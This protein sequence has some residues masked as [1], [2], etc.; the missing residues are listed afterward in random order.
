MPARKKVHW[1]H[2]I[3]QVFLQSNQACK[4]KGGLEYYTNKEVIH[5]VLTGI[6]FEQLA[7]QEELS[8]AVLYHVPQDGWT[9]QGREMELDPPKIISLKTRSHQ[10]IQWILKTRHVS[11]SLH[12]PIQIHLWN[13]NSHEN[14]SKWHH[15]CKTSNLSHHNYGIVITLDFI[16]MEYGGRWYAP[17]ISPRITGYGRHVVCIRYVYSI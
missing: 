17:R 14:H 1:L 16:L 12:H 8:K 5:R 2:F 3:P 4:S 10:P 6:K 13:W 11:M 7:C 9:L 15:T